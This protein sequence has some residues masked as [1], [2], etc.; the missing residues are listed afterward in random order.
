MQANF[1]KNLAIFGTPLK[2]PWLSKHNILPL[3]QSGDLRRRLSHLA[4]DVNSQVETRKVGAPTSEIG[5]SKIWWPSFYQSN[6]KETACKGHCHIRNKD[7]TKDAAPQSLYHERRRHRHSATAG[8]SPISRS[9]EG[10]HFQT[11]CA[12]SAKRWKGKTSVRLKVHP[13]FIV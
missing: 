3:S 7:W 4:G 2:M 13:S 12:Q 9:P 1:L 8:L 10:T 5:F 11:R 6:R